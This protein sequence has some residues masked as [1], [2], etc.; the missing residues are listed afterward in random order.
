MLKDNKREQSIGIC[1]VHYPRR[2]RDICKICRE[3]YAQRTTLAKEAI[4]NA[5]INL[6]ASME[7]FKEVNG[8]RMHIWVEEDISKWGCV[9]KR[10]QCVAIVNDRNEQMLK[11]KSK[12]CATESHSCRK[13]ILISSH[14]ILINED[15]QTNIGTNWLLKLLF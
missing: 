5:Q 12:I 1:M 3:T 11:K 4:K 6:I 7:T 13:F 15:S 2:E 9:M 8:P 14:G 10:K